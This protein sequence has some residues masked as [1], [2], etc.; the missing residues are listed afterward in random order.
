MRLICI[1]CSSV[2][3]GVKMTQP[4]ACTC[5]RRTL[6]SVCPPLF[7][8]RWKLVLAKKKLPINSLFHPRLYRKGLA[9][10]AKR[11]AR[12][13]LFSNFQLNRHRWAKK[14]LQRTTRS[15]LKAVLAGGLET[16]RA[17][18]RPLLWHLRHSS[19]LTTMNC[20]SWWPTRRIRLIRSSRLPCSSGRLSSRIRAANSYSKSHLYPTE[21]FIA[22]MIST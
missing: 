16:R 9:W 4:S 17:K 14:L 6:S 22:S 13:T 7:S 21:S 2:W 15:R 3:R 10:L 19:A 12:S 11:L 20:Y 8:E 5:T 18:R 1:R